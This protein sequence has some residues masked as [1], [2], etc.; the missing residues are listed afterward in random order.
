MMVPLF[1]A[2]SGKLKGRSLIP[3]QMIFVESEKIGPHSRYANIN[4]GHARKTKL[5]SGKDDLK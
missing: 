3:N 4:R 1:R 2:E 5:C